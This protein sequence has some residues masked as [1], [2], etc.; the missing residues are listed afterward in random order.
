MKIGF[1]Q[2]SATVNCF[3]ILTKISYNIDLSLINIFHIYLRLLKHLFK[4]FKYY[5]A[6]C[7]LQ[8][9]LLILKYLL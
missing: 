5:H 6:I 7:D 2:L 4:L 8:F 3:F 9:Y 1:M